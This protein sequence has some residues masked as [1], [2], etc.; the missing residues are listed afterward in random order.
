MDKRITRIER[1]QA[2]TTHTQYVNDHTLH[3]Q[4][5]VEE[6]HKQ[7]SMKLE[8]EKLRRLLEQF[9]MKKKSM[10]TI[11]DTL[12]KHADDIMESQ[13]K[14]VNAPEA[15]RKTERDLDIA[16]ADCKAL[17]NTMLELLD[18]ENVEK[19]IEWIRKMHAC[20]QEISGRIE[21]FI[22]AKRNDNNAKDNGNPLQLE[23]IKM[24]SFH[25]KKLSTI[26][27]RL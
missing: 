24:P 8:R 22:S 3:E 20:H 1:R 17:H 27:N 10:G 11:F 25:G 4:K 19:E 26:Q 23:K 16:L 5:G 9:S 15:L 14:D 12:V 6:I 21:A 7:E 13:N 18:H 2:A